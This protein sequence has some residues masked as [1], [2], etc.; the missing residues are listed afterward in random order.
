MAAEQVPTHAGGV[1]VRHRTDGMP[2]LLVVTGRRHRDHW[3]L[4]KGHVDPG[5]APEGTAVREVREESGV[6]ADVVAQLDDMAID[7]GDEHQIIRWFLMEA[8]EQREEHEL[9][10]V[11][12]LDAPAALE[13]LTFAD[14][15]TVAEHAL[16]VLAETSDASL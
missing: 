8:R 14:T 3:V 15:R 16:A 10:E 13:R 2:E 6:L 9:R 11:V 1:V 12:W 7:V 5:E 4:P